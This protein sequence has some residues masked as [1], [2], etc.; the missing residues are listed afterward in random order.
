MTEHTKDA[1]CTVDPDT[2]V[3]A[4]CGVE[5]GDPCAACGGRSFHTDDHCP[6]TESNYVDTGD[7]IEWTRGLRIDRDTLRA[8]LDEAVALLREDLMDAAP[9][10]HLRGDYHDSVHGRESAKTCRYCVRRAFLARIDGAVTETP[11]ALACPVE[12]SASSNGACSV[13]LAGHGGSHNMTWR[14]RK[15][16][17]G[18]YCDYC[19]KSDNTP[20]DGKAGA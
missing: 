4:I 8:Q 14:K 15:A 11:S 10:C 13:G 17:T 19:G 18:F 12:H 5:R 20:R 16:G 1:D 9:D 7:L 6:L 3:C 2:D